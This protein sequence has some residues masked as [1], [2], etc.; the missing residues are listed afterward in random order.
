MFENYV[1]TCLFCRAKVRF[2]KLANFAKF[3]GFKIQDSGGNF[4]N[5]GF[6]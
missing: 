5:P 2:E 6:D 1:E 3:P 4:L